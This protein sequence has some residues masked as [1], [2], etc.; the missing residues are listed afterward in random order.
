MVVN[1]FIGKMDYI[2]TI[3]EIKKESFFKRLLSRIKY[4]YVCLTSNEFM[5]IDVQNKK[6][7]PY[8][9]NI[10]VNY[11]NLSPYDIY[12][13]GKAMSDGVLQNKDANDITKNLL[14]EL[15]IDTEN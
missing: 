8:E 12:H 4:A 5:V 1:T 14:D 3:L 13:I 7:E 9:L 10:S 2:P 11:F 6:N 15:G